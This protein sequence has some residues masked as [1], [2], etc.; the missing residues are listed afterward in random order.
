MLRITERRRA[1]VV[2]GDGLENHY[3]SN[4]IGGSNPSASAL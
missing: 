3:T 2:E 1:R 4:G